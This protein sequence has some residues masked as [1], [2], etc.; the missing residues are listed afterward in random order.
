MNPLPNFEYA[1][2]L[3]EK[4][5][6]YAL[7]EDKEPDKAIAFRIALGYTQDSADRLIANIRHNLP[8][9][10]AK[11]NGDNGFGM[12]YEVVMNIHGL[13]GKNANIVTA[14]IIKHGTTYPRL[15]SAYVTNK[16]LR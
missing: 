16:K 14:W 5:T 4:F 11:V 10:E 9:Y 1:H 3:L 2:I 7:N 12:R 13:N 6:Q 15:T 8:L